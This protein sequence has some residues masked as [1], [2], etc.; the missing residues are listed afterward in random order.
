MQNVFITRTNF[1]WCFNESR[2]ERSEPCYLCPMEQEV[3]GD[4]FMPH[5]FHDRPLLDTRTVRRGVFVA[6]LFHPA[7]RCL[8]GLAQPLGNAQRLYCC[9]DVLE[10]RIPCTLVQAGAQGRHVRLGFVVSN[11]TI[12]LL[13]MTLYTVATSP[14]LYSP[15]K[16]GDVW[17]CVVRKSMMRQISVSDATDERAYI[18]A[19]PGRM[20]VNTG[21][22]DPTAHPVLGTT[23]FELQVAYI[24]KRKRR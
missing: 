19:T 5:C 10:L 1:P 3:S 8:Q 18:R 23:W 22:L 9:S 7:R 13:L 17:H 12:D 20:G 11:P 4:T 24:S 6:T 21:D 15:R 14:P 16:V 2:E